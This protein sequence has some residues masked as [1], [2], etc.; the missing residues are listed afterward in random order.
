MAFLSS[1]IVLVWNLVVV[2]EL[3]WT[4]EDPGYAKHVQ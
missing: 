2:T 1:Y 4:S 3:A